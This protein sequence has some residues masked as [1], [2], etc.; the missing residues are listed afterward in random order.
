MENKVNLSEYIHPKTDI[1]F[2][3]LNAPENSNSN[4]HWFTNNLSFWNLLFDSGIIT[5]PILNKLEGDEIVFGN[6]QINFKNWSIGVTDLNRNIVETKSKNVTIKSSEV[7]RIIEILKTHK[8]EKLCLMHSKVGFAFRD[9]AL[10]IKFNNNRYGKIGQWEKTEIFE[11]PFHN[12]S[13][14]DKEKYYTMLIQ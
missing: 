2:V 13:I 7:R 14:A 9:F 10:E 12:A 11:V 6:T 8:V 1:L 5:K 3:A 4:A